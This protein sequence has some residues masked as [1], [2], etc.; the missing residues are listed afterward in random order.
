[1]FLSYYKLETNPF[2]ISA[3][4]RF[5]W[6]GEKHNEA[7]ATLTYGITDNK[8]FLL[9]TGDVGSGKTTLINQ[10]IR[11]LDDNV[12]V[13]V[14][15]DPGLTPI[16]FFN[17]IAQRFNFKREFKSKG[18]F[19]VHFSMFLNGVYQTDKKVLLIID[20]AQRMPDEL[21]EEIRLLSNI[22]KPDTKLINIFFVGQNE[23]NR[24]LYK[25][26][27]RAL[28]QRMTLNY[29]IEP[30]DE[31]ETAYYIKHR[32]KVAGGKTMLFSQSA[33]TEIYKYSGGYPRQINIIC[34][35]ALLSGYVKEKKRIDGS[36]ISECVRELKIPQRIVKKTSQKQEKNEISPKTRPEDRRSIHHPIYYE[37]PPQQRSSSFFRY[38]TVFIISSILTLMVYTLLYQPQKLNNTINSTHQM[39]VSLYS[40]ITG[41]L[42]EIT[43]DGLNTSGDENVTAPP[44]TENNPPRKLS[45]AADEKIVEIPSQL[46]RN[47]IV[48]LDRQERIGEETVQ[49]TQLPPPSSSPSLNPDDIP[50]PTNE[51]EIPSDMETLPISKITFQSDNTVTDNDNAPSP[52]PTIPQQQTTDPNDLDKTVIINFK[53][54]SNDLS[55]ESREELK[56]VANLL[57][58]DRSRTL[59]I[60]GHSDSMGNAS[61]NLQLSKFRANIVKSFLVGSGAEP[62]QLIV[63]GKGGDEPIA[64]N[65]TVSGRQKNRRVE[66]NFILR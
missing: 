21:L 25:E 24:L 34:D 27:N 56:T 8:G 18:E 41:D 26:S 50:T 33:V 53:Y 59:Q 13:A 36:I 22:E 20:E 12:L 10:L 52:S 45:I 46:K 9:L 55:K 30:L 49:I 28:R 4:P 29:H 32:L 66:L 38:A 57:M 2:K 62:E 37:P 43:A 14:I 64:D 3:D 40:R 17:Q 7:L 63:E 47:D 5:L 15:S 1:M 48:Q 65:G 51:D 16:D 39:L 6:M 54:N 42:P 19:I 31:A 61:Y 60:T 23:F 11:N 35:L 44:S 58:E